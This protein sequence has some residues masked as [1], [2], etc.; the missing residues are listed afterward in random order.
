MNRFAVVAAIALTAG[1]AQAQSG[2]KVLFVNSYHQGYEW[3]DGVEQG[4]K[5]VLAPAGVTL[6]FF[7]MDTKN[8]GDEPFKKAAGEKAKAEIEAFKP[9]LVILSDDNAV[10][11]LLQPSYKDAALPFVF[12]GVNWDASR[13]GLPYK[14]A[15]GM[16][17][18]ALVKE[19]VGA[20]KEYGKGGRVGFLTADTET[21]HFEAAAYA[22]VLGLSFAKETFVK[23][24]ADWKAAFQAMQG[25]VD[26]L[27]LGTT[28]GIADWNEADGAAFAMA[29][30][31]IPSGSTYDFMAPIAMIGFTKVPEEQGIWAAKS[32]LEILKGTAPGS[33]PVAANKQAKIVVNPKLAAKAGVV[34]KPDLLRNATVAK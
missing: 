31:K 26:V 22:K 27:F 1:A 20:L 5:T 25:D 10:K 34:F 2:K 30:S 9:D 32:A 24:M 11:Y 15:T 13:Y 29:N 28:A 4:A 12:C 21:E 23:T 3:S 7:R 14:N 16:V 6:K 8:H 18:V 33:I 17:E 19:L